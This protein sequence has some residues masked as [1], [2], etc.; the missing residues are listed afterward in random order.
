MVLGML[1]L[2]LVL[3]KRL[4]EPQQPQPHQQPATHSLMQA[5]GATHRVVRALRW[6]MVLGMLPVILVS[7]SPLAASP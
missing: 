3:Y 5:A 6:R 7:N 1:P 2:M 4:L